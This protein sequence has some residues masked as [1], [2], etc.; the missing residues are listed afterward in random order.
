MAGVKKLSFSKKEAIAFGFEVAKKN[1]SFFVSLLVIVAIVYLGLQFFQIALNGQRNA[2]ASFL[3]AVIFW[4]VNVVISMG[5]I[6]IS[7]RFVDGRTPKLSD[8]FRT[9]SVLSFILVSVVRSFIVLVGILLLIVPGII[10]SIK[11]Q[12][13]GYLV[14]DKGMGTVDALNKSWE[15]TKGVK[16]NLFLFGIILVLINI[17]GFLAILVGLI[18]TVPLS[19]VANAFVYRRLLSQTGR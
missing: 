4:L 18:I 13:A 2:L 16:L 11:L 15:I 14:V 17:L 7:L 1:I 12:Y 19:M 5:V 3:Y 10:W 6:R 9:N 8:V